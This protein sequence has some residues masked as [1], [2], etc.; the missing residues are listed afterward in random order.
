MDSAAVCK[1]CLTYGFLLTPQVLDEVI[2]FHLPL[3]LDAG[4]VHVGVQKD[5]G[6]GQD[7]DG[8]RVPELAHQRSIAHTVTLTG[9]KVAE[10]KRERKW[11]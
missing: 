9:I 7:E 5:D 3:R 6:K 8:V 11:S 1:T 10:V 4:A 2:K